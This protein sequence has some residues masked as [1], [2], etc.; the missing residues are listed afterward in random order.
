MDT[1]LGIKLVALFG[2]T[3][4]ICLGLVFFSCRCRLN[5]KLFNMLWKHSWYQKFYNLHCYFWWAFIISVTI[6]VTLVI[7]TFGFPF[8]AFW[9]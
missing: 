9:K 6:H 2:L 1:T 3:N 7:M 4:L 8:L 5:H